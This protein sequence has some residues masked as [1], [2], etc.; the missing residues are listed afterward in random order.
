MKITQ[1]ILTSLLFV[2][3]NTAQA[4]WQDIVQQ[5][6][7]VSKEDKPSATKTKA[8]TSLGQTEVIKGLKEALAKG[9]ESAIATLGKKDG[10]LTN[11][12]VKI[13]IPKSVKSV[14]KMA[15]KLGQGKKVDTFVNSM[16]RAAESAVPKASGILGDAIRE[17]S[18]E[19]GVKILNGG[20]TAAT[21]YFR[22]VSSDKLK[23]QFLPIIKEATGKVGVTQKYK[24]FAGQA[25]EKGLGLVGSLMGSKSKL[26][27]AL[28]LDGYITQKSLDGL[29]RYIAIEEKAIRA[30]PMQAGSQLLE[31]VFGQ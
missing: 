2:L 25:S 15:K 9:V 7:Q 3:V 24:D 13:E 12:Q 20:D 28:D 8:G 11:K 30:N 4:G 16:N 19:D 1:I 29:F 17:M 27:H 31:K 23:K 5:A 21:D 10:F 26:N 6:V 18:V 22:K 14:A